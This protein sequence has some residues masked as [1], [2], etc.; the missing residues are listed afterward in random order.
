MAKKKHIREVVLVGGGHSH[1]QVLRRLA[2][3]PLPDAHLSLV[4]DTPVAVYS[5]MVPGFVAGQYDPSELEIDVLPLARRAG[6]RV[7]FGRAVGIDAD[8]KRISVEGRAAVAYDI[9]SIDIGS[10]VSGLE[11]PGVR[12]HALPTRPISLLVERIDELITRARRHPTDRDF[13]VAI[14]GGGA[15][16]VEVAFCLHE[17]LTAE[18]G[19]RPAI[20]LIHSG[21]EILNGYS[22]SMVR[23]VRNEAGKRGIEV[24]CGQRVARVSAT[25][26]DL[27]SGESLPADRIVWVTGA[28]SQ[29]IFTD[30]ELPADERGFILTRRTLQV[31]GHDDLFA[32]GDCATMIDFPETPKAGVYAV[33]QGPFLTDNLRRLLE[34][35]PLRRYR[36]Q[37]N[38]LTLLNLGDG[39]AIG[40]KRKTTFGGR[41][42]MKLKDWIDRRFMRRFQVLDGD[43]R[44]T[45]E[46]AKLPEMNGQ[47]MLCGGCAAKVGKTTLNRVLAR[48]GTGTPDPTV[49]MGLA[50]PDDAAS[51]I[52]RPDLRVVSSIDAFSAFTDDPYLVGRI[53]A[54]N[55]LS[56]LYAKGVAPRYAQALVS[57]PESQDAKTQEETL[58][59]VLAGAREALDESGATLVG[60]HSTTAPSL[61]VGFV[62]EALSGVDLPLL[63]ID[64]AVAGQDLVLTKPLGTGV[65]FRGDMKGR[66][67][68]PW[69]ER[70]IASMQRSN[71]AASLVARR[72]GAT[73]ATDITGFGLVGHVTEL[74]A[75]SDV[76]IRLFLDELPILPGA[77]ELLSAGER[78]TFHEENETEL[79]DLELAQDAEKHPAFPL[80]F[81]P[82]T[83]GGLLIC[84]PQGVGR[85]VVDQLRSTQEHEAAVI[86]EISLSRT[87]SPRVS[88]SAARST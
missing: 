55:A 4:V 32:V 19:R 54:V 3:E 87:G 82:Q 46:F 70:A 57:I 86:G 45:P 68:G 88:V 43:G 51:T 36:P 25:T 11:L 27:E 44:L 69:L 76:S 79:A 15:G 13:R 18:T 21:R 65:I 67:R 62:V 20:T 5:G 74:A 72:G 84:V 33:R 71:R 41:R 1:V 6:A 42:A 85:H 29:S 59:Q 26:V 63:A 9:A 58:F 75:A 81:D 14:V 16:G 77:L 35:T 8:Q 60:G 30:S 56:D 28:T 53:A 37:S 50:K 48:L 34:G 66:V 7:I 12:E 17:R 10:T 40:G 78:S 80:L 83:S 49:E 61:L 31:D 22:R 73:A 2:M 23:R 64:Q 38:F 24:V 47:D 39:T 52:V